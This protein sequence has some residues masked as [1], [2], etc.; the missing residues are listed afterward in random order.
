MAYFVF[1]MVVMFSI[2]CVFYGISAG[3][4]GIQ[5]GWNYLV[6]YNNNKKEDAL[7]GQAETESSATLLFPIDE[8]KKLF[9]LYQTGALTRTEYEQC[10]RYLLTQISDI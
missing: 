9:D 7:L 4:Q 1:F 2:S 6:T 5:R 8:L 10:K 3:V